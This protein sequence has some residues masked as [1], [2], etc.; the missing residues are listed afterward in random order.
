[1]TA[2]AAPGQPHSSTDC[3][4]CSR[5]FAEDALVRLGAHPEV[6]L[7]LDCATW[8]KRRAATKRRALNPTIAGHLADAIDSLR[9][10]VIEKGWHEHGRLGAFL[11]RIDR[12]L[13]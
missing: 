5:A 6:G 4:C 8:I 10:Y 2:A 7:C 3:W 13:P 1:M 9:G 12:Y 11:R